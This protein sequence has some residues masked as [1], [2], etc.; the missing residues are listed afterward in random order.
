MFLILVIFFVSITLIV[1]LAVSYLFRRGD[2]V[3]QESSRLGTGGI[4]ELG[5][6]DLFLAGSS[7]LLLFAEANRSTLDTTS[8]PGIDCCISESPPIAKGD[9]GRGE[10]P[11]E[12][13]AEQQGNS[14]ISMQ[15]VQDIGKP[16]PIVSF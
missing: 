8:S 15:G 14:T 11:D 12:P 16:T 10:K 6:F 5:Y 9:A 1:L 2:A 3:Q 4:E 7:S 13:L